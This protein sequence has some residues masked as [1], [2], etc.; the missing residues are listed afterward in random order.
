LGDSKKNDLGHPNNKK[1]DTEISDRDAMR[2]LTARDTLV[3]GRQALRKRDFAGAALAFGRGAAIEPDYP[4]HL[5]G[6]AVAAR[7]LGDIGTSE[8]HYRAAIAAADKLP[9]TDGI[10]P[11]VIAMHLVDFAFRSSARSAQANPGL[12][13]A[14]SMCVLPMYTSDKGGLSTPSGLTGPQSHSAGRFSAT[15]TPR[16]S[17]YCPGSPTSAD[18]W[19][20]TVRRMTCRGRQTPFLMCRNV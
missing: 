1:F 17:R 2:E 13:E 19:A 7:R 11:T 18:R 3:E 12:R 9:G 6:A 20:G 16:P 15:D 5:H 10:N 8:T 4:V 14:D